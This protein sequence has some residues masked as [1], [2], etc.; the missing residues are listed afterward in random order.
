MPQ[1]ITG[2][3]NLNKPVGMTSHDAVA[4]IRRLAGQRSVGHA[5]TLDPLASGVLVVLLGRCTAL[6][7]YAMASSKTYAAEIVFG[8]ATETDDAEGPICRRGPVPSLSTQEMAS[9]LAELTGEIDQKPPRYSAVKREG[10]PAYALARKGREPEL[11]AR[12]VTIHSIAISSWTPPRLRLT[13]VTGPGTYIRSVAR[14][15]GELLESAAYLHALVRLES[16]RFTLQDSVSLTSLTPEN[17]PGYLLPSDRGTD[18]LGAVFLSDEQTRIASH[19]GR[20]RVGGRASPPEGQV[21]RLYGS[22]GN[23]LG[24]ARASNAEW[25]PFRVLEP[26]A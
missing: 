6:S 15:A 21:V 24:L 16:G 9:R 23:L 13:I 7:E 10:A 14:D 17:L 20:V 12:R 1:S 19:G 4:R 22:N 18:S 3:L 26:T 25:H 2:V 11:R 5:G 8:V